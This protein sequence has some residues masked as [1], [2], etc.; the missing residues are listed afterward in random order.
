MI[1]LHSNI[2]LSPD[3]NR[4]S[5]IFNKNS[6]VALSHVGPSWRTTKNIFLNGQ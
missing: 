2:F 5:F 6:Y 4:V 3:I 1:F